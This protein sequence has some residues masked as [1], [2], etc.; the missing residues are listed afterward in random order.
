MSPN[1]HQLSL[2]VGD[3]VDIIAPA[4]GCHPEVADKLKQ[5][6]ESWG[7]KCHIPQDL[8]GD[9]LLCANSD[10]KRLEHLLNAL[11][12]KRSKAVWCLLGGYGSTRLIPLLS[13]IKPLP[14]TKLFIGFSDITAL[15]IFLQKQWGWKTI[16]GPSGRQA[17]LKLVADESIQLLKTILFREQQTIQ[18]DN[19]QPLNNSAKQN[20]VIQAP[21]IGG[22]LCL[23][24]ASLGTSWQIDTTNKILLVEETNERGYRIDRMFEHLKQA[25]VIQQAKAILLGDFTGGNETDGKSLVNDTL[26]Q[27]ANHCEIPVLKIENVGHGKV[28]HPI[29]FGQPTELGTG[30][31]CS[32]R[33]YL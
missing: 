16:H 20:T 5:F 25:G 28:N 30:G 27:F 33:L 13:Q 18:F 15:H 14:Q 6:L 12:N 22:N 3:T 17:A 1:N 24:E 23:I 11:S 26:T 19:L 9:D 31:A 32:L 29:V 4:A 21:I 2:Q 8:F 10:D 7:L